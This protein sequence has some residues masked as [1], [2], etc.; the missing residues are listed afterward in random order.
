M[1]EI[2]KELIKGN[3]ELVKAIIGNITTIDLQKVA[4]AL[5]YL[6]D[7]LQENIDTLEG[8]SLENQGLMRIN[9]ALATKKTRGEAFVAHIEGH[10]QEGD[11]VICKICGK[12]VDEIYSHDIDAVNRVFAKDTP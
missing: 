6:S 1:Y 8:L 11:K 2:T 5:L 4:K 3:R 10:L 9:N 7:S 12:S